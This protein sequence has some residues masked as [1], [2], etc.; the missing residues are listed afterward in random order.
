MSIAGI[1]ITV[2]AAFVFFLLYAA[3]PYN[4]RKERMRE[5]SGW[6]Y[7]H[8]GLHDKEDAPENSML[9]FE[10]AVEKGYGIE[11]D[12]RMTG[13]NQLVIM[14]DPDLMR[15]AGVPKKISDMSLREAT[16]YTLFGTEEHVPIFWE[17]LKTV[18]GKVPLIIEIKAERGDDV[19]EICGET[20]FILDGYEGQ[21]CIESFHPGVVRWF[22]KNRPQTLRGQLSECMDPK[23][24]GFFSFS[25]S[26]C[27]FNFLTK[28]DFIAYNLRDMYKLPY[29][30]MRKAADA[31]GAA[32]TVRSEEA[33]LD[34]KMMYDVFI[35]ENF[36]PDPLEKARLRSGGQTE[37]KTMEGIVRRHLIF[38]GDVQGVGFR[39]HA[40]YISQHLGV[41]GW[42]KNL[43]DGRVEMEAQGTEAQIE[44]LISQLKAQ[45]FVEINDI[46]S[47]LIKVDPRSYEFK[48]RY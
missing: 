10:R 32:W 46:E 17:V 39:Y 20:A 42:V 14:H 34:A 31:F 9:A 16:E 27:L 33:L 41:T 28:P 4:G 44:S 19:K 26:A 11:L 5:F 12:V 7:A 23:T 1:I 38:S 22:R 15:A 40:N 18:D 8:R 24:Q 2:I 25:L 48:V 6:Y 47:E 13:D 3:W 43:Y 37:G 30:Y 36:L 21:Y 29:V 45:R 35:F